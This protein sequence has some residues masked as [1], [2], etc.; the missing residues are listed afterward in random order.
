MKQK[1]PFYTPF[2][3]KTY[4]IW[5]CHVIGFNNMEDFI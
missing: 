5:A 1:T 2:V 4:N 3:I